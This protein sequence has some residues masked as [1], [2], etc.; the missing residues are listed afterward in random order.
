MLGVVLQRPG[1][2]RNNEFSIRGECATC[3]SDGCNR[4]GAR[5]PS[6]THHW[7]SAILILLNF[8]FPAPSKYCWRG[9]R[10]ARVRR[11]AALG[12][13]TVKKTAQLI[14]TIPAAA[15]RR[16][17]KHERDECE[18]QNCNNRNPVVT[19]M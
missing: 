19:L 14:V 3:R 10:V 6:D 11:R 2:E 7:T 13:S 5:T 16:E 15:T 8:Q 1:D 17:K 18:D 4:S 9:A 12:W